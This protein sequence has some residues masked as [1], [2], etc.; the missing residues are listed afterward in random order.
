M[1]PKGCH[2]GSKPTTFSV[3][4]NL[5]DVVKSLPRFPNESSFAI[6]KRAG[7]KSPK[8][9]RYS[10]FRILRALQW[11]RIN[12]REFL[13]IELNDEWL[14]HDGNDVDEDL[15][16]ELE[17][18]FIPLEDEDF[19]CIENDTSDP[20]KQPITELLLH[21]DDKD[22]DTA[23]R[24]QRILLGDNRSPTLTRTHGV[25]VADYNTNNFLQKAFVRCYPFGL[26]APV[27][28]AGKSQI[29]GPYLRHCL[30]I[31]T[32]RIF[33]FE[34]SF[35]FYAYSWKM[36][37]KSGTLSLLVDK[38][39][40]VET[41]NEPVLTVEDATEFLRLSRNGEHASPLMSQTRMQY[42]LSLMK[43]PMRN[44]F[45]V[46]RCIWNSNKNSYCLWLTHH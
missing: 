37:Q 7:D 25:Y 32:Q 19:E 12:N 40:C 18:P 42:L 35:V 8:P 22:Y 16:D 4:N 38:S 15:D 17:L 6:L 29:T 21:S 11:L 28:S 30:S 44:Y 26:G 5:N 14:E 39:S 36:Q 10:P 31:G 1:L 23:D 13:E 45:L 43:P 46:H 9:L 24:V 2:Y 33:Q 27:Q 20:D 41:T 34:T 3:T